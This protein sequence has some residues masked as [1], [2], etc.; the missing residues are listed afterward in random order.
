MKQFQVSDRIIATN[1]DRSIIYDS[2]QHFSFLSI[3]RS[4]FHCILM[5]CSSRHSWCVGPTYWSTAGSLV[6]RLIGNQGS[7]A[8]TLMEGCGHYRVYSANTVCFI[9]QHWAER[10]LTEGVKASLA[11]IS[12]SIDNRRII[13]ARS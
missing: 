5:A 4:T 8:Y 7:A 2:Y 12:K 1:K 10:M 3:Y 9:G 11:I 13:T 6:H